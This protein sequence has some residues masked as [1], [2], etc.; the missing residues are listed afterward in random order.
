MVCRCRAENP[1]APRFMNFV[2]SDSSLRAKRG[3]KT[4]SALQWQIIRSPTL[5]MQHVMVKGARNFAPPPPRKVAACLDGECREHLQSVKIG[6]PKDS[7]TPKS[8][9]KT[10]QFTSFQ[11]GNAGLPMKYV[12]FYEDRF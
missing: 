6:L 1:F 4:F 3:A 2:N 9:S 7:Q 5:Q 8:F 12:H 11:E 10:S